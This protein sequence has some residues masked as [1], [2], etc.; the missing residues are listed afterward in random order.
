MQENEALKATYGSQQSSPGPASISPTE[1]RGSPSN[2]LPYGPPG[3]FLEAA[4]TATMMSTS[5]TPAPIPL[6]ADPSTLVV[7]VPNN[8]REIRRSLHTLFAPLLDMARH[9]ESA[10]TSHYFTSHAIHIA[11]SIKS[12]ATSINDSTSCLHRSHT[13]SITTGQ[14]H[15]YRSHECEFFHDGSLHHRMRHRR[16]RT[17]DDLGRGLAQRVLVGVLASC[18]RKIWPVAVIERLGSKGELLEAAERCSTSARIRLTLDF[19]LDSGQ[20]PAAREAREKSCNPSSS[21][22]EL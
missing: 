10:R 20:T 9:I 21:N 15:R 5:S 2:Y 13:L 18:T 4:S 8:I 7:V 3:A 16:H 1:L 22:E 19:V 6:L 14:T 12:N 11:I 17:D